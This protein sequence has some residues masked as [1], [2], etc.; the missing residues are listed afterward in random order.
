MRTAVLLIALA[1]ACL[2]P[3]AA[4]P[5]GTS[6]ATNGAAASLSAS[7]TDRAPAGSQVVV[8]WRGPDGQGDY[9]TVVPAGADAAAYGDF[10]YAASGDPLT[11]TLPAEAGNYEL[12]YVAA[13]SQKVLASM[14]IKTTAIVATLHVAGP[15]P[16]G[17]EAAIAWSGPNYSDD[18]V[19][20]ADPDAPA[21]AITSSFK[22]RS[23]NPGRLTAPSEPGTYEVR[24]ITQD[25]VLARA[26]IRVLAAE[27]TLSA[28]DSASAGAQIAVG[29]D[30]TAKDGDFIA[31]AMPSAPPMVFATYLYATGDGPHLL[32]VPDDPGTYE[33]R[34]VTRGGRILAAKPIQITSASATLDAPAGVAEGASFAVTWQG[35]NEPGDYI[36]IT[37]A[38]DDDVAYRSYAYA[39]DGSPATLTAPDQSGNFEI[40]YVLGGRTV[41][42]RRPIQVSAQ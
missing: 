12:R 17:A 15:V 11:I 3:A 33:L 16:A 38:S 19:A 2:G 41:I 29:F 13:R 35:P 37:Q 1:T 40:R 30:G 28:P 24:Y 18:I 32:T 25:T 22:T 21:S 8:T 23:G 4:E 5:A 20:I 26:P 7:P 14:P 9:V 10:Q 34:Y 27:Q 39:H 31:A 42:A 36:T 6:G